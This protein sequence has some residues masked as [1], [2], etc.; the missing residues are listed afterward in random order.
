MS[1]T[2]PA[3]HITRPYSILIL[4]LLMLYNLASWADRTVLSTIGQ[5]IK[6][7]LSLSDVELGFLHGFAFSI[8]YVT[9]SLPAARLSERFNRVNIISGSLALW[10]LF[11]SLSGLAA[12][13]LQLLLCRIGVGVGESCGNPPAYSLITDYFG[14]RRR[15]SALSIYQLGLPLGVMAG[16]IAG[17]ILT[18][19]YG[20]RTAFIVLGIPGVVL[21]IALK[22]LVRELPRGYSDRL[23][24]RD[25]QS[26]V[27]PT[28]LETARR[29][30]ATPAARHMIIGVTLFTFVNYGSGAFTAPFLIRAFEMDYAQV[31]L[32]IGFA[33]GAANALGTFAGG[34]MA[35]YFG[36]SEP[37]AYAYVPMIGILIAT[38]LMIGAFLQADWRFAVGLLGLAGVIQFVYFSPTYAA[39]YNMVDARMRA[40]TTA[41]ISLVASLTALV[42]G[43][44]AAGAL[45]DFV[46]AHQFNLVHSGDFA[47][48]CPGG[49]APSEAEAALK[50]ACSSAI[51]QGTRISLAVC[52]LAL[53]W[54]A[55]HFLLAARTIRADFE[56]SARQA[57]P[58][59]K[60][61]EVE[62]QP[63]V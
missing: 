7:D 59:T 63:A 48:L 31:G 42:I 9:L 62:A 38:P 22:L 46:S 39:I 53:P 15:A 29:L 21:A 34:F 11:T 4:L 40:T 55:I 43:T 44:V 47:L 6:V 28:I 27:S 37:R 58:I 1:A 17:G 52:T 13:F 49:V 23:A 10:S 50:T 36:K 14:P 12:S 60:T 20:W 41:L 32:I 8:L 54:A 35:D 19:Y 18:Q 30:V 33:V 25:E 26:D 3:P 5:A 57:Q 2:G 45:I 56:R 61:Q 24:G 16:A 51:D